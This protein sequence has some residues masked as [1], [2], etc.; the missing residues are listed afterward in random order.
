LP[1]LLQEIGLA[2][3]AKDLFD[4]WRD[5]AKDIPQ[6]LL[7]CLAPYGAMVKYQKMADGNAF[8]H[9]GGKRGCFAAQEEIYQLFRLLREQLIA[10][11]SLSDEALRAISPKCVFS[12]Q[13]AEGNR[14]CGRDFSV[15]KNEPFPLRKV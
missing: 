7:A 13:C 3:Q 2:D 1:P 10:N 6:D 14:Y 9:E 8:L 12:G 5:L 11:G 15:I 4:T